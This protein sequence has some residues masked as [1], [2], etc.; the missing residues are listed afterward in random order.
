MDSPEGEVGHQQVPQT[1]R[2]Y[3]EGQTR[4]Q[5]IHPNDKREII[6]NKVV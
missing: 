3:T 2:I 4:A 1:L 5:D 6:A